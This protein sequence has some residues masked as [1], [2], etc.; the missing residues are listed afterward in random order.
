MG[1]ESEKR[2]RKTVE[3]RYKRGRVLQ[4]LYRRPAVLVSVSCDSWRCG[5][6]GIKVERSGRREGRR[7]GK[8]E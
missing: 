8:K 3:V 7:R 5:R 2:R 1:G 6:E 4:L